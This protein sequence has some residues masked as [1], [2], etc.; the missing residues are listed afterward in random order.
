MSKLSLDEFE[1]LR[2]I[3]VNG[4]KNLKI[5]K[6]IPSKINNPYPIQSHMSSLFATTA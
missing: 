5:S 6:M 1:Y 2:A 4:Q 3:I